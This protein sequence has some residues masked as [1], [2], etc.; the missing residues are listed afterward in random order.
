LLKDAYKINSAPSILV[1]E[2]SVLRGLQSL[3]DLEK[4]AKC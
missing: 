1:D 4:I 3:P 2:S